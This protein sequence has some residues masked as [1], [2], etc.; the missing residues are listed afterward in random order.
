MSGIWFLLFTG[1]VAIGTWGYSLLAGPRRSYLLFSKSGS[2]IALPPQLCLVSYSP[3]KVEK[4]S[5]DYH[6]QSH[7]TSSEIH[8]WPCFGRLDYHPTSTLSLCASAHLCSV[9]VQLF[10]KLVCHTTWFLALVPCLPLVHWEL[11]FLCHQHSQ[12]QDQCS[13]PL[14][15]SVFDYNSL[16]MLFSFVWEGVEYAQGLLWIMSSGGG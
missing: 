11:I 4:F 15:L 16:F 13:T 6:P 2:S 5:F 10:G 9:I 3:S 1:Q 12:R 8:P 14:P 7:Q